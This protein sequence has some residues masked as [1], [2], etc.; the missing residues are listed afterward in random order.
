[1]K[2]AQ[3][4]KIIWVLFIATISLVCL[5]AYVNLVDQTYLEIVNIL[6]LASP[7]VLT[8][9]H[10]AWYLG[11]KEAIVFALFTSAFSLGYEFLGLESGFLFGGDYAYAE[12]R[13]GN[14]IFGVPVLVPAFWCIFSYTAYCVTN[15]LH[16]WKG[17]DLPSIEKDELKS[18][19]KLIFQDSIVIVSIDVLLDPLFV[20]EGFWTWSVEGAYYGIPIGNFL[21]WAVMGIIISTVL[22][23]YQFYNPMFVSKEFSSTLLIPVIGYGSLGLV[24][25]GACWSVGLLEEAVVGS[26]LLFLIFFNTMIHYFKR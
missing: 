17:K 12:G 23:T 9:V 15:A 18:V 13:L 6:T 11:T 7:L 10:A 24:L 8:V 3:K 20:H 4:Y 14:L 26:V 25:A 2:E 21:G 1:M 19:V 22:R 5:D 16:L